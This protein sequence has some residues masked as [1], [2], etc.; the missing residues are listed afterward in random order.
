MCGMKPMEG[1]Q[2]YWKVSRASVDNSYIS[3]PWFGVYL[4]VVR[5][6]EMW[7]GIMKSKLH[8]DLYASA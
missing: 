5:R 3:S 7:P 6:T 8:F 2:I 4:G 1:L